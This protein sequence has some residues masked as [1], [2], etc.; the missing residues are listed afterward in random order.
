MTIPRFR[1]RGRRG[2]P[3]EPTASIFPA[4]NASLA[5]FVS[6]R[7][8]FTHLCFQAAGFDFGRSVLNLAVQTAPSGRIVGQVGPNHPHKAP[9]LPRP[10]EYPASAGFFKHQA[11]CSLQTSLLAV[12]AT[13]ACAYGPSHRGVVPGVPRRPDGIRDWFAGTKPSIEK[14]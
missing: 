13:I 10:I 1:L 6:V 3:R 4:E 12:S 9:S 11:S 2:W 8:G 14:N 7:V 5:P